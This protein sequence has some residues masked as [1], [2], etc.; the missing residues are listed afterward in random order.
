MLRKTP[1]KR[2]TRLRAR[3]KTSKHARRE[4]DWAYLA[5]VHTLPCHARLIAQGF[6]CEGPIE[7]DHIGGRYGADADR[8]C[9]PMCRRHH[10]ERTGIVGGGGVFA[11]WP[12]ERKREWGRAAIEATLATWEAR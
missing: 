10:R 12:L 5:F 4:R 9:V 2:Y 11:G 3:S 8:R 1:L 7:A 6:E